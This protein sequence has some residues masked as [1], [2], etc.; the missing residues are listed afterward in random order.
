MAKMSSLQKEYDLIGV[1]TGF[2]KEIGIEVRGG[3]IGHETFLPGIDVVRGA[4]VVDEEK[5]LYPG[6]LL[7]EAGHLAVLTPDERAA[8]GTTIDTGGGEEMAA[9]AW[10]YAAALHLGIDPAV[11]FHPD[12]YKG[13]SAWIIDNF[14][15]GQYFAVPLLQWMGL[16]VD[17]KK[18]TELSIEPF[19]QMIK[20]I[21]D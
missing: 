4:L 3:N 5:L 9:I 13:N 20:W 12:G 7:H 19:P 1:I 14:S 2:L 11:V 21:R 17:D 15:N 10:S 6:D 16:T 18:A 8:A